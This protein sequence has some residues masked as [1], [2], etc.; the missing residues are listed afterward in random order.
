MAEMTL[1]L[2][3]DP[4]SGKKNI[5]VSLHADED[6]LPQEHE[7]LHRQLVDKLL[8]G[9]LLQ[10]GEAGSLIIERE[11]EGAPAKPAAAAPAVDER[12]SQAEG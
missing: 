6:S 3:I 10:P 8:E 9:G 11:E 12:Q 1:R 4:V 7:Q 2:Q 5:V